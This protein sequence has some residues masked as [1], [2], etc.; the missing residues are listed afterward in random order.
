MSIVLDSEQL[1]MQQ[2][3]H[4]GGEKLSL[5]EVDDVL[6]KRCSSLHKRL[7]QFSLGE[8]ALGKFWKIKALFKAI[9]GVLQYY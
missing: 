1:G 4:E 8:R 6:H 9:Q 7:F 3:K 5:G 2:V